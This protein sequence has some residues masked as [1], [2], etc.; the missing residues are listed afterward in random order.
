MGLAQESLRFNVAGSMEMLPRIVNLLNIR[1]AE[2][3]S[4][5][6]A[7]GDLS[8][9]KSGVEEKRAEVQEEFKVLLDYTLKAIVKL[10]CLK[11]T[12]AQQEGKIASYDGQMGK[13]KTDSAFM[14][15][16]ESRMLAKIF[17]IQ[18]ILCHFLLIDLSF[19]D[20]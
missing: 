2:L 12:L 6:V 20:H 4:F 11:R 3:R 10:T 15:P 14:V 19:S 1:D 5:L 7:M 8:L 16:K 17:S 13:Q 18:G 9:R